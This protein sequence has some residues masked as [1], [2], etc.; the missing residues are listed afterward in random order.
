MVQ[1]APEQ[2]ELTP[3]RWV[4]KTSSPADIDAIEDWANDWGIALEWQA[5]PSKHDTLAR[6]SCYLLDAR[7]PHYTQ[8]LASMSGDQPIVIASDSE[9]HSLD[10]ELQKRVAYWIESTH[11]Q[12]VYVTKRTMAEVRQEKSTAV[13]IKEYCAQSLQ[14]M[15]LPIPEDAL[16]M[17]AI[18]VRSRHI[19][20]PTWVENMLK[21]NVLVLDIL[22][23]TTAPSMLNA[24]HAWTEIPSPEYTS[25]SDWMR[26]QHKKIPLLALL[27]RTLPDN[28]NQHI[29]TLLSFP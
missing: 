13:D 19:G 7:I 21:T 25:I 20:F 23:D 18:V 5:Q 16:G 29:E 17:R 28:Q 11:A 2:R 15:L 1:R 24:V 4:A 10:P 26:L 8:T 12:E 6:N 14:N 27:D 9:W 22:D 3:N